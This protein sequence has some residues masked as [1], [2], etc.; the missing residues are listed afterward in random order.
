VRSSATG[1]LIQ[2]EQDV[3]SGMFG[4]MLRIVRMRGM[5]GSSKWD[6]PAV[7]SDCLL[8]PF[9]DVTDCFVASA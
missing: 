6:F 1:L 3:G 9:C 8:R 2:T 5:S 4:F 7:G